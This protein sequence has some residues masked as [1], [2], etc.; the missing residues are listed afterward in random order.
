ML[1]KLILGAVRGAINETVPQ[2]AQEVAAKVSQAHATPP[3]SILPSV[4]ATA[5]LDV[6]ALE[7]RILERLA[8]RPE[9]QTVQAETAPIPWY[10]SQVVV[11][12]LIALA[13]PLLAV[14]GITLT[15]EDNTLIATTIAGLGAAISGIV[16]LYGR[17]VKGTAQPV[18]LTAQRTSP[19]VYSAQ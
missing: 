1:D 2:V 3:A 9:F 8:A 17:I 7:Q 16:V 4:A 5:A 15:P 12:G 10:R 19:G 14:A 18:T 6:E 11:G 13:T